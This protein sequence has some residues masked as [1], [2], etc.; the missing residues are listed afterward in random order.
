MHLILNNVN[1]KCDNS[2]AIYVKKAQKVII[3]L[4][5]GTTNTLN[6]GTSYVYDDAE[7]E[8]PNA[9][10]YSKADLTIN[11]TGTLVVNSNFNNGIRSNDLLKLVNGNIFVTAVNNAIT[12][13]D[14][15]LIKDGNYSIF[16]Y[17]N[18]V[19][20][21]GGLRIR[22]VEYIF[23]KTKLLDFIIRNELVLSIE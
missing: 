15:I 20:N 14:G 2:A 7:N 3:T 10:L 9:A 16:M 4:S 6:D 21:S 11:G 13:K 5:D 23:D 22:A 18:L 8:E 12:G 17:G 1:I 19:D